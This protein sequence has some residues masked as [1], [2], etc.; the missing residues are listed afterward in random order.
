MRIDSKIKMR[1]AWVGT[2]GNRIYNADTRVTTNRH[3]HENRLFSSFIRGLGRPPPSFSPQRESRAL[4]LNRFGRDTQDASPLS[5]GD[6]SSVDHS[7]FV[8]RIW[9]WESALDSRC[10]EK[11]EGGVVPPS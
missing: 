5:Q 7:C 2:Q 1:L 3:C 6:Q 4:Y 10:G 9:M 11:D 8:P